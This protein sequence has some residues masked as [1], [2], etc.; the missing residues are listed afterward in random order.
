MLIQVPDTERP[1][2]KDRKGEMKVLIKT[3]YYIKKGGEKW[4]GSKMGGNAC[5]MVEAWGAE[6]FDGVK[7]Y[8]IFINYSRQVDNCIQETNATEKDNRILKLYF[9]K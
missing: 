8:F 9:G 2:C 7:Q 5:E 1:R 4:V 3:S 6:C